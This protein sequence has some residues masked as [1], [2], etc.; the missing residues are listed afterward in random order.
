MPHI[1][2]CIGSIELALASIAKYPTSWTRAIQALSASRLRMVT[3]LLRF[4]GILRAASARTLRGRSP[5]GRRG[6]GG[7]FLICEE[8]ATRRALARNG[9]VEFVDLLC[10]RER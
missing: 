9:V 1:S 8:V 4:T 3:Y 6:R 7:G 10:K 5:A 2:A